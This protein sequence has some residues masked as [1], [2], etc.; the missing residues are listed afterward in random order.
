MRSILLLVVC[1]IL[2]PAAGRAEE[3]S[4]P[5]DIGSIMQE[6]KSLSVERA[7]IVKKLEASVALQ[8]SNEVKIQKLSQE[9]ESL[10]AEVAAVNVQARA[11]NTV[12]D[13]T[14]PEDEYAA[15]VAQCDAAN[16]VYEQLAKPY[17]AKVIIYKEKVHAI[18]ESEKKRI[19][20]A[21]GLLSR[22][23]QIEK[24]MAVLEKLIPAAGRK[25][26]IRSC[27]SNA[28][29]A[30][31]S[32]AESADWLAQCMQNCFDGARAAS[33]VPAVEAGA[34]GNANEI[35]PDKSRVKHR[36]YQEAIDAYK[37]SGSQNPGPNTLK[38]SPVPLP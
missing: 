15:A 25:E 33:G 21:E 6:I 24:R 27:N 29:S 3:A 30:G 19:E 9:K 14:V 28:G 5:Q 32:V 23:G 20:A 18:E 10:D 8:K 13:R 38:T 1:L 34:S 4:V 31:G 37:N 22:N 36:T 11:A 35:F 17:E 26:C 12:C 7:G 16:A 2:F